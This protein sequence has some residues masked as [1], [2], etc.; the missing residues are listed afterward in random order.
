VIDDNPAAG[1]QIWRGNSTTAK[2]GTAAS[3]IERLQRSGSILVSGTR[4]I[5]QPAPHVLLAE[6]D[7]GAIE[8]RYETL[9]LA[10]GARE[11]FLPFPGWTLPH[12]VGAG[13]LQALVKSGMP[14]RGKT[15][16]VA[17]TGPLLLAVA[18]YLKEQGARIG[19]IAEQ[20]SAGRM[21]RFSMG[22][23]PAKISRAVKLRWELAGT[24]YTLDCWPVSTESG[25]VT[26]RH[27]NRTWQE[28]CDFLACG[29]GLVPN[30]ELPELLGCDIR[31]GFVRVDE[32]Q[33]TSAPNIYCAGEPT[34]IG[35]L[36]LALVEGAIAGYASA[37]KPEEARKRFRA[38]EKWRR[39]QHALACAFD[40]RPE[41]KAMATPSTILCRC[42]DV[43]AGRVSEHRNWQSAKLQTRC[44]MGSCQGRICGPAAEFLF[45][46]SAKSVRPPVFSATLG[47][48]ADFGG[49]R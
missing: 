28:P 31:D 23:S 40:L 10:T 29:F 8:L 48:F 12:V 17:G 25:S 21:A 13:G 46:W 18:A 20:T 2:N 32:W 15:V 19:R 41:L 43:P 11:L 42:E 27:K 33:Q 34:G 35:G 14:V 39:F 16:V 7:N 36:D 37:G 44:G 22:L 5:D 49:S 26:L 6:S 38:R 24:P 9:I 3:W 47:N 45:G 4:V 30:R 1:G